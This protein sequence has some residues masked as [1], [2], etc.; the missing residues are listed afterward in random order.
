MAAGGIPGFRSAVLGGGGGSEARLRSH[1]STWTLVTSKKLKSSE[2][3]KVSIFRCYE[4]LFDAAMSNK[5]PLKVTCSKLNWSV[6]S[7]SIEKRI[8][9]GP[10]FAV[11]SD[12]ARHLE[13]SRPK[14]FNYPGPTVGSNGSFLRSSPTTCPGILS[15]QSD[16][17]LYVKASSALF[18]RFVGLVDA[19]VHEETK[20]HGLEESAL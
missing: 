6:T 10:W 8:L 13:W 20:E 11:P 19:G 3:S 1:D 12:A 17:F 7:I 2:K 15:I 9:A 18:D 16:K 5:I 14:L 4:T